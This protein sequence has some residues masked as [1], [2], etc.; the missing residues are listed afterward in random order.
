MEEDFDEDER[1]EYNLCP[2]ITNDELFSYVNLSRDVKEGTGLEQVD[3]ERL[4]K[5]GK[6]LKEIQHNLENHLGECLVCRGYYEMQFASDSYLENLL[7][8]FWVASPEEERRKQERIK[9]ERAFEI[10]HTFCDF[11]NDLG[12]YLINKACSK[13]RKNK[14]P[15]NEE[16]EKHIVGCNSCGEYYSIYLGEFEREFKKHPDLL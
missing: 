4:K 5:F 6:D 13:F 14:F 8:E 1:Q 15:L 10:E 2:Y 12:T 9:V 3:L 11:R 16:F 7:K